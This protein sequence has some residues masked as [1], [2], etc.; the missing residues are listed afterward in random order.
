VLL[1]ELAAQSVKGFS[2]AARVALKPGYLILKSPAETCAPMAGLLIALC[3][4]DGRGGDVSFLATGAKSGKAGFSFQG[5][6]QSAWRLVRELGGAGSLHKL[7]RTNNQFEVVTQDSAEMAQLLRATVGMPPRT[8]FEQLFI[9]QSAQL[10]T[11]R[12]KAKA[13]GAVEK[14]KP[15]LAQSSAP[16]DSETPQLDPEEAKAKLAE[17]KKELVMSKEVAQI[18]F[19]QDGLQAE[20]FKLETK[21]KAYED[22]KAVVERARAEVRSLPTAA[23]LSLSPD[24]VEKVKRYPAELQRR[25]DAI[26][27]VQEDRQSS[28]ASSPG[29]VPALWQDP[30]FLGSFVG[31]LAL[32]GVALFLEGGG[33]Y[34]A[35]VAIPGFTYAGLLALHHIELLQASTRQASR[36]DLHAVREKKIDQD[37]NVLANQVKGAFKAA[38]V[39]SVEEF[40]G[41]LERGPQLE[42]KA[43]QAQ[44]QLAALE[45]D[46]ETAE[47][48][49][50]A[51][52]LK[53]EQET[54]TARLLEVSGGYIRDQRDVEREIEKLGQSQTAKKA[55]APAAAPAEEF[56]PV[57]TDPAEIF[58][59]PIPALMLLGADL[60]NTDLPSLWGVLKDR[61]AQYI[62]ALTDR[63]LHGIEVDKDGK[64]KVLAPGRA[65]PVGELPGKDLDL[66]YLSIRL[67]LIEKYSSQSKVPVIFEDAFKGIVDDAKLP[68]VIRMLKHLGTLTQILHVTPV[69]HT[70]APT[71]PVLAL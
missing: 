60:F 7:N 69:S 59:D 18:Q 11:R 71:E 22:A 55:P 29:A 66:V 30:K 50:K 26:A 40:V 64:A 48:L 65:V 45:A 1:L 28:E 4:P 62:A 47:A 12:P 3:F 21:V 56:Q 33:R 31:G 35:L 32:V 58:D 14:P 24:I 13:A 42:A 70:A 52:G 51:N 49:H 8:T 36:V 53:A 46:P 27:K 34:L 44:E 19:R 63:R 67:T 61:S 68:L 23:S 16:I 6:D 10:P 41:L 20:L 39:E 43:A 15:R 5:N 9:F 57:S 37:F 17:L 54:I 2:P 38:N 25:D